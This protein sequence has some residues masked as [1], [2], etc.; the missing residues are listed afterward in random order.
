MAVSRKRDLK[1]FAIVS[2]VSGEGKSTTTANLATTSDP[3]PLDER[4]LAISA[5]L[6][7]PSLY[8][9][10]GLE[11]EIGLSDILLGDVPMDEALQPASPN[12][13]IITSGRPPARPGRASPVDEDV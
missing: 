1:V 4:V 12:L 7:R 3:L 9:Y 8:R 11:N 10:F 2:P 13:W 6:R 5:D